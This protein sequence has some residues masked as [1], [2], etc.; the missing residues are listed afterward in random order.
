MFKRAAHKLKQRLSEA[1]TRIDTAET[2]L[3]RAMA[4]LTVE[5]RADKQI[6][7]DRLRKALTEL[8][9]ARHS[10]AALAEDST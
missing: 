2:E 6:V 1:T 3:A 4:E 8:V 9:A 10:L 7:G 5:D